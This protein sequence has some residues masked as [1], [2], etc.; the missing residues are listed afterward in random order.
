MRSF[1]FDS[2]TEMT[3]LRRVSTVFCPYDA[4][5]IDHVFPLKYWDISLGINIPVGERIIPIPLGRNPNELLKKWHI[6]AR[7]KAKA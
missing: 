1:P 3:F 6:T 2:A 4:H 7:K 5:L